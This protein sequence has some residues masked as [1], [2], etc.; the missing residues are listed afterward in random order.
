MR[1]IEHDM[2]CTCHVDDLEVAERSKLAALVT[3]GAKR[4]QDLATSIVLSLGLEHGVE[5]D[6]AS[7]MWF[8]VCGTL[9]DGTVHSVECD[10]PLD[11]MV[12]IWH[13][14]ERER[15]ARSA[16]SIE[17]ERVG[18]GTGSHVVALALESA[19]AIAELRAAEAAEEE[20]KGSCNVCTNGGKMC[21][22]GR[23]L[24]ERSSAVKQRIVESWGAPDVRDAPS[25]YGMRPEDI[26]DGT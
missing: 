26:R 21:R 6:V 13:A 14:V 7:D 25:F 20:H 12:V 4:K 24:W 22:D 16:L 10:D 11:G 3:L 23:G 2:V 17:D 5:L 1:C 18:T 8:G 19:H 9:P 15:A